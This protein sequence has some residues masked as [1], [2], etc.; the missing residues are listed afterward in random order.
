M[1]KEL[2]I[3]L[4]LAIIILA[5]IRNNKSNDNVFTDK[6]YFDNNGTTIMCKDAVNFYVQSL[7][8]GNAS[9]SYATGAKDIMHKNDELIKK[10]IQSNN[11]IIYTSGATESNVTI[12]KSLASNYNVPH[13][14][15]SS[16][17]HV[18]SL[19]CAKLLEKNDQITL[20]LVEPNM[21]GYIDPAAVLKLI[22]PNTV[23]VSIMHINNE[24]GNINDIENI[25]KMVKSVNPNIYFH[26]DAVQ[27]FGKYS[28][29][30]QKYAIDAI[31]ASYHKFNGPQGIGL[32]IINN[33]LLGKI[34]NYPLICGSQNY[35]IRGGTTNISGISAGHAALINTIR[36]REQ[37]NAKLYNIKKYI[38]D[39]LSSMYRVQNYSLF[40]AKPDSFTVNSGDKNEIIFLGGDPY[41]INMSPNTILLSIIKIGPIQNHFCNIKFKKDLYDNGIIVSIGSACHTESKE[42]SHVL[43]A[44]KAPYIIRCGVVRIS[45]GDFNT[46]KEAQK[47]CEIFRRCINL[48][49]I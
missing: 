26:T 2:G 39:K 35:G 17:E 33:S 3:I 30:M 36:N 25:C 49:N 9:S 44:I 16:Y 15:L 45:L 29:P 41:S 27:S 31:S 8:L 13:F 20:S 46:V 34:K 47:F 43:H 32:L 7:G 37:K 4:L 14:I 23:L 40:Y 21:F 11:K 24:L 38:V 5:Y 42:P 10:W 28:I 12:L 1:Y 22:R 6:I 18:S 19:D 48:Q